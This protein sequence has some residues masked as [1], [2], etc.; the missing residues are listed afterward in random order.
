[1]KAVS[2]G[3]GLRVLRLCLSLTITQLLILW[4]EVSSILLLGLQLIF[5]H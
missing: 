4:L 2:V 3:L 5:L 1:M